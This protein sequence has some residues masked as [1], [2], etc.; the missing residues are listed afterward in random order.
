VTE[1]EH[2]FWI[3]PWKTIHVRNTPTRDKR[4]V[5]EPGIG[6]VAENDLLDFWS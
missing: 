5:V 6:S 4:V 3:I 2:E 1:L